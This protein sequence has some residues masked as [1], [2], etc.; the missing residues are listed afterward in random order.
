MEAKS[1]VEAF[2]NTWVARYGV[3]EA[4][5]SDRGRQFTSAL[6]EGLCQNLQINHISTTAYH[7]QSNGLV[8][9]THRQIALNTQL[10]QRKDD[11]KTKQETA[12]IKRK[13][14]MCV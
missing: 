5:T 7:P 11:Q 13:Q 14:C 8:E 3:P 6:W 10:S 12:T 4:V 9:R 2:I 1:C